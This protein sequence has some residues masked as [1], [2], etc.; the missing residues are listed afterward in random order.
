MD[1]ETLKFIAS[2]DNLLY[3]FIWFVI[4]STIISIVAAISLLQIYFNISDKRY[5]KWKER[6]HQKEQ[7][8][9]EK[10]NK[11]V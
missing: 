11:R 9:R 4:G 10:A 1:L 8:R 3:M 5:S 6:Q 2:Q 7:I